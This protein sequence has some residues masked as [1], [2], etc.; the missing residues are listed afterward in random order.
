MSDLFGYNRAEP[1]DL[2]TKI[3]TAIESCGDG[4]AMD[5]AEDRAEMVDLMLAVF[6]LHRMEADEP[7]PP[8]AVIA[9]AQVPSPPA[10]LE[11]DKPMSMDNKV[12][13]SSFCGGCSGAPEGK[14][15]HW[16]FKQDDGTCPHCG[17]EPIPF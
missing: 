12:P 3:Q 13:G 11:F 9:P 17:L 4:L 16:V 7:I 14:H 8:V 2:K 5:N 15:G 10:V 6:E 1:M